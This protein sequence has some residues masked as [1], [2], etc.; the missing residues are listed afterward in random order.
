[1]TTH[2]PFVSQIDIDRRVLALAHQINEDYAGRSIDI[3]CLINS[4][5][6]FCADIVRH[7]TVP[8]RIHKMGFSSYPKANLSGEVRITLDVADSL[9]GRDVLVVE[10][11]LVSGRTPKYILD[12]LRLRQPASLCLCALGV[13]R[14]MLA[15]DLP[16]AYTA[17]EF[18]KEIVV[19]YGIGEEAEMALPY[20]A[21][22]SA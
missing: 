1:M 21:E 12:I 18:G 8:T 9:Q 10:G 13:K 2:T 15:V 5:M 14:Q 19:G 3:V 6:V 4:A 11:I 22:R 16:L 7:L 17:F 20:L